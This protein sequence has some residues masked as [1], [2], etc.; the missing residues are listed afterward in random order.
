MGIGWHSILLLLPG[1]IMSVSRPL[2]PCS[3]GIN[4]PFRVR[5][6][7]RADEFPSTL[8]HPSAECV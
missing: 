5:V 1:D 4:A 6:D 2:V 8:A 3:P 7:L